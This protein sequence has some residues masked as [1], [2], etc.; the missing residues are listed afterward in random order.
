[1]ILHENKYVKIVLDQDAMILKVIWSEATEDMEDKDFREGLIRYAEMVELYKPA[2]V[3]VNTKVFKMAI[4][5]DTQEWVD[6]Y[7]QPRA[8]QAG[9]KYFAY[10]VSE[11]LFS[12]VSIEQ[13]ME[14][15][16]AQNF[17]TQYFESEDTAVTWLLSIA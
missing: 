11:D 10:I 14:E 13:T 4:P 12:Q 3:L 8:L 5:P 1:M 15:N 6:T 16:T 9:V 17:T 2:K 7:I